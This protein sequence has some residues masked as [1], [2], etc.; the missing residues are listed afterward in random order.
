M[1]GTFAIGDCFSAMPKYFFDVRSGSSINRDPD[2]RG[3]PDIDVARAE[4]LLSARELVA[5]QIRCGE[6]IGGKSL[7]IRDASGHP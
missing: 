6:A 4:G 3:L 7:E 2:G 1:N 5:E